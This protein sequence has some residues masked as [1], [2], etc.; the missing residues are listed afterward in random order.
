MNNVSEIEE[1]RTSA[2]NRGISFESTEKGNTART[3]V[4][5]S[6]RQFNT[7]RR[8]KHRRFFFLGIETASLK[9]RDQ[10]FKSASAG[11]FILMPPGLR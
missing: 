11:C 3:M 8:D 2:T 6:W 10:G 7:I 5:P 9:S 4:H 1:N